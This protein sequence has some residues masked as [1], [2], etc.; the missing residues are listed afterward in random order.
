MDKDKL[1]LLIE[2]LK[3]T[4]PKEFSMNHVCGYT[5]DEMYGYRMTFCVMGLLYRAQHDV[6][7]CSF[8]EALRY[9]ENFLNIKFNSNIGYYLFGGQWTFKDELNTIEHAIY[10]I[11]K[12]IDGYKP[13]YIYNELHKEM[14]LLN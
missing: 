14:E 6:E 4:E 11:Q 5:E 2:L 9:A 10:R 3:R 13:D 7:A 12:V 1:Q 8:G